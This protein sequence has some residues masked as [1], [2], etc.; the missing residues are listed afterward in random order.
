MALRVK[1][2]ARAAMQ[3]RRAAEW[4]QQNRPAAPGA[5]ARDV[6]ESVALLAEQSGIGAKYDGARTPGVRR[7]FLGR[8]GYFLYYRVSDE[9]LEVLALW[10]ASREEQPRV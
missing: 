10:H 1:I 8:I 9:A 3:T 4:W 6:G 5:V 2:S 7:L